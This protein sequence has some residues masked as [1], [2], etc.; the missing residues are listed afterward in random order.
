MSNS[1]DVAG[2][3][4]TVIVVC[5]NYGRYLA[6]AIDS[7]LAQTYSP[8]E[9][10]V[11][12]DGSSD[13][14]V[15]VASRY[16][17]R[18]RLLTQANVGLERTVNRA[19]AAATGTLF[20]LLSADDAYAPTYVATLVSALHARNGA[21][22]AFS[23]ARFFGAR[24]GL[25]RTFPFSAY[26]VARRLNYVNGCALTRREDFLEVGGYSE[27][28]GDLALEDWDFWLKMIEAGKRGTYVPQ[29]LLRWR[30][31]EGGSR[32]PEAEET[33][34]RSIAAIRDRH[35][36][37]RRTLSD[38]RGNLA[39]G[40][41]LAVA[42]ID[43]GVGFSRVEPILCAVERWSWRRFSRWHLPRLREPGDVVHAEP[44]ET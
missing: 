33:L 2:P 40:F 28:L 21:D 11:I 8:L 10:L 3:L 23:R 24:A 9:V 22:F 17:D 18:I 14:S 31:H 25:T 19:V 44:R 30:R 4:V 37:L 38:R 27:D 41:D 13:D 7:A 32:N 15:A 26:H 39:Y 1:D 42:A 35:A 34:A 36:R 6:E 20:C 29:P 12:D 16:A 43:L 5:H